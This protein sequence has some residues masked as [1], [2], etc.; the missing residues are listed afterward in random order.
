MATDRALGVLGLFSLEKPLWSAEEIVRELGVSPSSAYRYLANLSELGL[1]ASAGGG[2]YVLGPAIIQLDRQIQ[3]TDPMLQVARPVMKELIEFAPAGSVMLLCRAFGESVLCVHQAMGKG[4]QPVVSYE[5][6]K[7]ML[8]FR[9]A[10]SRIILAFQ[11]T[12]P[13]QAI[14]ERNKAEIKAAGLGQDWASFRAELSRLRR[15][16]FVVS[17]GEVDP[18][19]VGIAAPVQNEDGRAIGSLSYV[20]ADSVADPGCVT[21]LSH[22]LMGGAREIS[23]GMLAVGTSAPDDRKRIA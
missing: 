15:A 3:L 19:R 13:L 17:R 10:T 11:Q 9:G 8:M 14:Y 2:R 12:R 1:V 7:P 18:G 23:L 22:V 4:P 21:R 20:I 16:G 6:G 5:R